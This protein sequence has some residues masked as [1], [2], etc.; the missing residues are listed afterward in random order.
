MKRICNDEKL[1][2]FFADGLAHTAGELRH[3]FDLSIPV[4]YRELK[5]IN[6]VPALNKSGHYMLPGFRRID[7]NGLF[8]ISGLVFSSKGTLPQTLNFLVEKS[9]A[10]MTVVELE[11]IVK[12]N[13]KVQLLNL[14]KSG[15]LTRQKTGGEYHYFSSSKERAMLQQREYE[16]LSENSKK[17]L[18]ME[19]VQSVPFSL[20]VQILIVFIKN[21]EFS[22]KSIALSL[23][24]RGMDMTT[25]KVK[26]VFEKYD[27]AKKNS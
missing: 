10:G 26:A 24:R 11:K 17:K 5:R 23:S 3:H 4:A 6:A 15:E 8:R 2:E 19:K 12:T 1:K 25:E 13:A 14:V 20:V 22:P 21:P 9:P 16:K 7:S 27:L 18:S